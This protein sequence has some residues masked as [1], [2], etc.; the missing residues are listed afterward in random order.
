MCVHTEW[1][2]C[3]KYF[4][5]KRWKNIYE[6][7]TVCSMQFASSRSGHVCERAPSISYKLHCRCTKDCKDSARVPTHTHTDTHS[8]YFISALLISL[9]FNMNNKI[10]A[11][12]YNKICDNYMHAQAHCTSFVQFCMISEASEG[13]DVA[14][15]MENWKLERKIRKCS[16][17]NVQCPL[18]SVHCPHIDK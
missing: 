8:L 4:A 7:D 2:K 9:V 13:Y 10:N 14:R 18:F 12:K 6:L 1:R 15:K 11:G 3:W 17:R 16:I 5:G